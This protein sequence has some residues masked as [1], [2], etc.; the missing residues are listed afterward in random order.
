MTAFWSWL[1]ASAIGSTVGGSIGITSALSAVHVAGVTLLAGSV[2]V[3]ALRLLGLLFPDAPA[4]DVTRGPRLGILVGLV[5]SV[6]SGALLFSP[7]AAAAVENEFFQLKMT[8]LAGG[9]L[10][11][12]L[13]YRRLLSAAGGPDLWSR[14]GGAVAIALWMGVVGAGSAYILLE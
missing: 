12:L 8:L 4:A 10:F 11:H 9:I 1:E 14:L 7:R 6:T 2:I 13:V 5:V 3:S